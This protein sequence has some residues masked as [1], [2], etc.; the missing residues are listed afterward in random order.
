MCRIQKTF[1]QTTVSIYTCIVQSKKKRKGKI[2]NI[3][4][5]PCLH[6]SDP[7]GLSVNAISLM[8]LCL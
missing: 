8:N 3:I 2:Y 6:D 1:L 7:I 4:A 5:C